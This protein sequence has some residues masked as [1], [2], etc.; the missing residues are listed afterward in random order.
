MNWSENSDSENK[1]T[2]FNHDVLEKC[3]H[4]LKIRVT[5]KL[6]YNEVHLPG[7]PNN[8]DGYHTNCY[9]NFTAVKRNYVD[10]YNAL[11]LPEPDLPNDES[12]SASQATLS[13]QP[14]TSSSA[15]SESTASSS[16]SQSTLPCHSSTSNENVQ[17]LEEG[18]DSDN[19]VCFFCDKSRKI[20]NYKVVPIVKCDCKLPILIEK[21]VTHAIALN[22]K[23]ILTKIENA[24]S[25]NVISYHNM[26]QLNYFKQL[27]SKSIQKSEW[28]AIRDIHV[29]IDNEIYDLISNN[30]IAN[31]E[32]YSLKYLVEYA[33]NALYKLGVD[34]YESYESS[35]TS[36]YLLEKLKKKFGD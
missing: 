16:E 7:S 9:S 11:N 33:K 15:N 18:V 13:C 12:S 34:N 8:I 24:R 5:C 31:K 36:T 23:Q 1:I 27:V 6:K 25:K 32:C 17:N 29:I 30:T 22:D 26:C 2:F 21:I 28:H 35:L 14:S 20:H 10:K 19:V 3:R 4:I